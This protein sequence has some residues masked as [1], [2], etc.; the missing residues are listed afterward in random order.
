MKLIAH[1]LCIRFLGLIHQTEK[2]PVVQ[3]SPDVFLPMICIYLNIKKT[4]HRYKVKN[5]YLLK[6]SVKFAC[7]C[8]YRFVT[9][10]YWSNQ[11]GVTAKVFTGLLLVF[12]NI[13][14]LCCV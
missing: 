10:V 3:Q 14:H 5:N 11:Q 7:T 4:R 6:G 9:C 13:V 8:M 12:I 1:L 2:L